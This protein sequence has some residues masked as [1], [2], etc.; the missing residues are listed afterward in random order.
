MAKIGKKPIKIP[1]G[2]SVVKKESRLDITGPKGNLSINL[3]GLVE[4][5]VKPTQLLVR[6]KKGLKN[7]K[8]FQGTFR[9]IIL[10]AIQG[11]SSG[12]EKKLEMQGIGFKAQ[13][14]GDNLKLSVG[15]SHPVFLAIPDGLEVAVEKNII[16]IK[17]V[18]KEQV[19]EFAS[20]VRRVRPPEPY[21]GKGIR[22]LGEEIKIKPGKKVIESQ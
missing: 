10:N 14:E 7:G 19:G 3:K 11:V 1:E 5:A 8:V 12:F 18:D 20:L 2:V 17:G 13:V 22:Y 9:S 6:E 21:K 16:A 15:F 4:V